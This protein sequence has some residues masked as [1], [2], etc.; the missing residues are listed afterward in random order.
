MS[1][2][3]LKRARQSDSYDASNSSLIVKES[4]SSGIVATI[5]NDE[6]SNAQDHNPMQ[7]FQYAAASSE[8][9][10]VSTMTSM[11]KLLR[12]ELQ[13]AKADSQRERK[14]R[15]LETTKSQQT[16]SR[17]RRQL[18]FLSEESDE[19]R[20]LME[21]F[22]SQ[23][24]HDL[25][26]M[27][28]R[29]QDA[30]AVYRESEERC[31]YYQ[32]LA[33]QQQSNKRDRSSLSGGDSEA[34]M[35]EKLEALRKDNQTLQ[36]S[37]QKMTQRAIQAE[38]ELLKPPVI[39]DPTLLES[40]SP[41]P[42]SVMMELTKCRLAL[43]NEERN[44]KSLQRTLN[45]NQLK[46]SDHSTL[47]EKSS[48]DHLR[49]TNLQVELQSLRSKVAIHEATKEDWI[50]FRKELSASTN[51][52]TNGGGS[53]NDA[54]LAEAM[55]SPKTPPRNK[56]HLQ[57][58]LQSLRS[59][60][61]IHE[62]TKED[63]ILFRKELSASTNTNTNSSS[64]SDNSAVLAEAMQS[65][66]TPPRNKPHTPPELSA[67]VRHIRSLRTKIESTTN[68]CDSYKIQLEGANR[69]HKLLDDKLEA[70]SVQLI[71]SKTA[72]VDLEQRLEWSV[73]DVRK[74]K[75]SERIGKSEA[76][77][78]RELLETYERRES[79]QTQSSAQT[80]SKNNRRTSVTPPR[81]SSIGNPTVDG[82]TSSLS[83][84]REEIA[85]LQT[86]HSQ[87]RERMDALLEQKNADA[88]EHERVLEKFG[89]LKTALLGE[90][91]KAGL[92]EDCANHAEALAGK[93]CYNNEKTQVLH[94]NE[95]PL[96]LA[97]REKHASE[98]ASL[99]DVICVLRAGDGGG[100]DV[101]IEKKK[102]ID[103]QKYHQRLKESFR[104]QISL[105]R[106]AIYLLTADEI[107][108]GSE[109]SGVE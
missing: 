77:T 35:E 14:R 83:T 108:E 66:K 25:N 28:V 9:A 50:L 38:T 18:H 2:P 68:D 46:L 102:D 96:A 82:L 67:V 19:S 36:N 100:E 87:T 79:Q 43:S 4:S 70:Q 39:S 41:A 91:E 103:A 80:S 93:G 37:L 64:K 27:T 6:S 73:D 5:E 88:L 85:S 97:I 42:P 1:S 53:K 104:E 24:E 78:M 8:G 90:R 49:L 31:V 23:S 52:N 7:Q 74:A 60:V 32:Q 62:A 71:S 51:T 61:A 30:L 69:R 33:R 86:E 15:E 48:H 56:P 40:I 98:L 11:E 107:V 17:L 22:R 105:F 99:N 59:K 106:E 109:S 58:E 44:S 101:A 29:C 16:E 20:S 92:V 95:N 63:W 26:E 47:V 76:E 10:S 57:V 12:R 81:S 72:L 75:L 3:N 65:P 45:E 13:A 21:D 54:V 94:L 34:R 84:A 89:K 55:Q